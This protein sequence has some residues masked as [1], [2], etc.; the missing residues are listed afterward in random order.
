MEEIKKQAVSEDGVRTVAAERPFSWKRFLLQWEWILF[1]VLIVVNIINASN[2]RNYANFGNIMSALRDFMDKAIVVFPMAFIIMLGEIDIS[3]ASTMAL[4][5]VVMG[6]AYAAGVP[7]PA[8]ICIALL[9]GTICGFINGIILAKFSELSSM[10]VTLATQ[11]IYRG[12]AMILLK[13]GSVTFT[14]EAWFTKLG[15]GNLGPF[16]IILVFTVVEILFF[17]YLMHFTKFG[18]RTR[19][20]GSQVTVAQFSGIKTNRMKVIIYTMTGLFAAV[21]AVFLASKM[22]S[23]RPDVAKGYELDIIAMV[24]L[25]GVSTSGGKGNL[26]GCVISV[27]IVGL[28][29]YGLG[30]MNVSSQVIM[31]IIGALLVIAVAIPGI[32][33]MTKGKKLFGIKIK[34]GE[35]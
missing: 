34:K 7:L 30:L 14:Q 21:A 24:V 12:I 35:K 4:S 8:A 15:W 33:S 2:S 32:Q 10:I 16:P 23:T 17:A 1:G 18:R 9:V 27:L 11:I 3:V 26:L 25:G 28:L 22:G 29:R 6:V 20:M 5:S 31:I 13:T 19:A